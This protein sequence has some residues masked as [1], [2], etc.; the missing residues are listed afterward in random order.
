M[1]NKILKVSCGSIVLVMVLVAVQNE[2]DPAFL[3]VDKKTSLAAFVPKDLTLFN[4]VYVRS[5]I[6]PD[7]KKLLAHARKDGLTLKV[8]SGY[9][10]FE[11]QVQVFNSWVKKEL[12][13]NPKLTRREA[14]DKANNYSAK[15]GHSEHQL[16]TTV[17]I[18]SSENNYQFSLDGDLKYV[19]WLEK[20]APRYNFKISYPKD[21][22]EYQYEPWHV[23]WYPSIS[24]P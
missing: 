23:R 21:G 14:E 22:I 8:V 9:R 15:A 4:G 2:S 16:G 10:S 19:A 5:C 17:D 11:K 12:Q 6:I 7:L 20:N 24:K 13:K 1:I 18:L 3:K